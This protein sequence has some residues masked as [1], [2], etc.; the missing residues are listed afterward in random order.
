MEFASHRTLGQ[1]Y[2]P[3]DRRPRAPNRSEF[4]HAVGANRTDR[5]IGWY[6]SQVNKA[7]RPY[8]SDL[9][10]QA[11]MML[12]L[13]SNVVSFAAQPERIAIDINH[14]QCSYTPDLRVELTSRATVYLEVKPKAEVLLPDMR[15]RLLAA[16]AAINKIGARFKIITDEDLAVEPRRQNISSLQLYRSVQPDLDTTYLIDVLLSRDGNASVGELAR[17]C[18]DLVLG[19]QTVMSLVYRRHLKLNLNAPI[20][21]ESPV[22]HAMC[23]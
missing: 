19:R 20:T 4:V 3:D 21:H 18:P 13:T 10:R 16:A 22:M 15:T 2:K 17:L 7:S 23:A 12:D 11:M 8:H 5:V 1:F 6:Q 14:A 9:E